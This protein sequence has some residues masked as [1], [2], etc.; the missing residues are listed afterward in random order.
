[1][2]PV[3]RHALLAATLA[4]VLPGSAAAAEAPVELGSRLYAVHCSQCHG[5]HREGQ[6]GRGPSLAE[7]GERAADFYLRTGYMPLEQPGQ[8]PTRNPPVFTEQEL[9]ALIAFAALGGGP[10]VPSPHPEDGS[11]AE[12]Q[13]LFASNCAGCHQIVGEGGYVTGVRAPPLGSATAVQIAEAVRIG[14]YVMPVFDE[15]QISGAELNSIVA[16]VQY[17]RDPEDPGGWSIGRLGPIPE[18]LVTWLLAA[19]VLVAICTLIGRRMGSTE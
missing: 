19:A 11:V 8:E 12:G 18:G 9:R 6:A 17:A 14:P 16:Y 1:M 15:R 3:L 2:P 7:V 13:R 4:A 5:A 10:P